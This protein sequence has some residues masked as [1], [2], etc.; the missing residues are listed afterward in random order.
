VPATQPVIVAYDVPALSQSKK[1][2][3]WAVVVTM[4][5]NWK[6][7][8]SQATSEVMTRLGEQF[9]EIYDYDRGLDNEDKKQ[10]LKTLDLDFRYGQSY[11]PDAMAELLRKNGPLW[12]TVDANLNSPHANLVTGLS[13]TGRWDS[14]FVHTIDPATG[15]ARVESFVDFAQ[16]YERAATFEGTWIYVIHFRDEPPRDPAR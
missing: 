11:M 5:Q 1:N 7:G 2:D 9:K 6:T 14:C 8:Q 13:G 4:L 3:C 10:L 16:R 15:K 12:F